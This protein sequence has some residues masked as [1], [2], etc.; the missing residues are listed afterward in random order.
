MSQIEKLKNNKDFGLDE[1]IVNSGTEKRADKD[2]G[3]TESGDDAAKSHQK[4]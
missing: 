3:E 1:T 4:P 2:G